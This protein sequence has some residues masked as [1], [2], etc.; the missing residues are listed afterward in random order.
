[1]PLDIRNGAFW[2]RG[3]HAQVQS[4]WLFRTMPV[5]LG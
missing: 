3:D 5:P 4:P 2:E 1:M